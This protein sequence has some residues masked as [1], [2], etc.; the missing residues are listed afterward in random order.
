MCLVLGTSAMR[1]TELNKAWTFLS[2]ILQVEESF[3][4]LY[5][6]ESVKCH[7]R[8]EKSYGISEDRGCSGSRDQGTCTN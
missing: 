2:R 7:K 8:L 5:K 4:D 3:L 1:Y 6:I